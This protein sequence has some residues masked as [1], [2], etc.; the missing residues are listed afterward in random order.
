M[1]LALSA[2]A[3][4]YAESLHIEHP[5]QNFKVRWTRVRL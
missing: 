2:A 5:N 4:T 1:H 3:A